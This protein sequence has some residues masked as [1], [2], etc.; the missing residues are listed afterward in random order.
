MEIFDL[1]ISPPKLPQGS[2]VGRIRAHTA[3]IPSFLTATGACA[4]VKADSLLIQ[5][6][7]GGIYEGVEIPGN[8]EGN[9]G[10]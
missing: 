5:Y 9:N 2:L 4:S 8:P 7:E 3:G 1:E 6:N 10:V